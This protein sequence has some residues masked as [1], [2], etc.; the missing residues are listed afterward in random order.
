MDLVEGEGGVIDALLEDGTVLLE[1]DV[2]EP[3]VFD[4]VAVGPPATKSV[5]M[6]ADGIAIFCWREA[7]QD[8]SVTSKTWRR[9]TW[10]RAMLSA[11]MAGDLPRRLTS[12]AKAEMPASLS[13]PA[14]KSTDPRESAMPRM[15]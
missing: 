7:E 1:L 9:A 8:G 4:E 15:S 12:S 2:A 11:G 14:S 5:S 13:Q 6:V 10:D 3:D